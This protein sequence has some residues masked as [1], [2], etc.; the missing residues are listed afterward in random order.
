MRWLL[1]IIATTALAI[2][3][4]PLYGVIVSQRPRAETAELPLKFP[5]CNLW[6]RADR[7]LYADAG[8]TTSTDGG[9]VQQWNDYS[10]RG[11]HATN[12]TGTQRPLYVASSANIGNLP[13][14]RFDGSNDALK[15]P[16]TLNSGT[17]T[18]YIATWINTIP[19]D[20]TSLVGFNHN[21]ETDAGG[22][23][24]RTAANANKSAFYIL[25]PGS[26]TQYDS[27]DANASNL[28]YGPAILCI[29]CTGG[30]SAS[31]HMLGG[32]DSSCTLTTGTPNINGKWL[33]GN[34]AS[35]T[36]PTQRPFSGDV[37][38]VI[39][40]ST[41]HDSTTRNRITRYL[42]DKY[43]KWYLP[44]FT[45]GQNRRMFMLHG[46]DGIRWT[47][48]GSY[49][50]TSTDSGDYSIYVD[51]SLTPPVYHVFASATR[52]FLSNTTSIAHY[53][54]TDLVNWTETSIDLSGTPSAYHIGAPEVYV[55]NGVVY[56]LY[57]NVNAAGTVFAFYEVHQQTAGNFASWTSPVEMTWTSAPS[58]PIDAFVRK[59]GSTYNLY[60]KEDADNYIERATATALTG[61][62]TVQDADD[63]LGLGTP[64]EGQ[65]IVTLLSG[66]LR[67]FV[68]RYTGS[69]MSYT[70]ST[71][72]GATWSAKTYLAAPIQGRHGTAVRLP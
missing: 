42:R 65:S 33:L 41:V 31:C 29:T 53:Y 46:M 66:N 52:T 68:D 55:E 34:S 61:P 39:C 54:S 50:T 26:T 45:A 32:L 17:F 64:L 35:G 38:E 69:G 3:T 43:V 7:G 57:H 1:A 6:L 5:G 70:D 9:V 67:M 48:P 72:S 71:D 2:T 18:L 28:Y 59:V 24:V 15:V 23:F 19:N 21:G 36:F 47:Y 51:T 44:V 14:V 60:Y 58:Q 62:Y 37:A 30:S 25:K 8:I 63:A 22:F 12:T 20:Y 16:A 40:Y 10:G 4:I 13:V 56:L 49:F 27:W 11:N